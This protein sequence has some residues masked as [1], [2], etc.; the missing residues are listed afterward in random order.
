MSEIYAF[1]K[2]AVGGASILGVKANGYLYIPIKPLLNEALGMTWCA[3]SSVAAKAARSLRA[4][5]LNVRLGSDGWD[6]YVCIRAHRL[7]C[8]LWLL[9]PIKP[10]A[11]GRLDQLRETWPAAL[12]A[13]FVEDCPDDLADA[14]SLIAMTA[15]RAGRADKKQIHALEAELRDKDKKIADLMSGTW[16]AVHARYPD[17]IKLGKTEKYVRIWELSQQGMNKADIAREVEMSRTVVSLFLAGK[18][19]DNESTRAA[20]KII[21]SRKREA[22]NTK[23]DTTGGGDPDQGAAF[24]N[25]GN[26]GHGVI[27]RGGNTHAAPDIQ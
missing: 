7:E 16:A 12:A 24:P 9:K 11:R 19:H 15:E 17:R 20:Q 26:A 10:Q 27:H 1:T 6:R 22:K 25:I 3:K 18:Y 21:A 2:I 23:T 8:L 14:G 13:L 5:T 4:I